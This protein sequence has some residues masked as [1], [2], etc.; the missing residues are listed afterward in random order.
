MRRCRGA[1]VGQPLHG[2]HVLVCCAQTKCPLYVRKSVWEEH[3]TPMR[4]LGRKTPEAARGAVVLEDP[5]SIHTL[6]K[7]RW[8]EGKQ[9]LPVCRCMSLGMQRWALGAVGGSSAGLRSDACRWTDAALGL[10]A[11]QPG[12]LACAVQGGRREGP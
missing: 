6:L 9:R 4:E 1:C 11:M 2:A 8:G 10:G 12:V 5:S 3:S 7:I